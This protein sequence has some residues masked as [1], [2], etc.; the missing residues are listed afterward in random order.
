MFW[1]MSDHPHSMSFLTPIVRRKA[2]RIGNWLHRYGVPEGKA[3][4]MAI[5]R[6]KEWAKENGFEFRNLNH[7]D[8]R[9][10]AHHSENRYVIPYEGE[11][12]VKVQGMKR[13][14]H[15]FHSKRDAVDQAR[16]EAKMAKSVLIILTRSG[17]VETTISYNVDEPDVRRMKIRDQKI[18]NSYPGI[19]KGPRQYTRFS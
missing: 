9:K 5:R 12:A 4:S 1:T 6:A 8:T 10:A 18:V 17:E 7:P 16:R 19:R 11:W 15:V 3:I 14:E 13:V 2:I